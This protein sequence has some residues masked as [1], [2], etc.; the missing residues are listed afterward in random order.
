M[1]DLEKIGLDGSDFTVPAGG[2]TAGV[3]TFNGRNG[4]VV[5]QSGDYTAAMVGLGNVD[6]TSDADKPVSTA[7]QAALDLKANAADMTTALAAKADTASLATVATSGRYNDLSD[8]PTIPSAYTL[9]TASADELGGVKVGS[10][11]AI[12]AEGVLSATGGGGGSN[13]PIHVN[14]PKSASDSAPSGLAMLA[15]PNG[16]RYVY[17]TVNPGSS[18]VTG[19]IPPEYMGNGSVCIIDKQQVVLRT[20]R[21][22]S[23]P[24]PVNSITVGQNGNTVVGDSVSGATVTFEAGFQHISAHISITPLTPA[25]TS[26]LFFVNPN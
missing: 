25:K 17:C 22:T 15:W 18:D 24:N 20:S 13:M 9:P 23:Q 1:A 4:A 11:L 16:M 8:K 3:T 5:P 21:N 19:F 2:A 6:N 10:G 26:I 12:S 14:L 7:T